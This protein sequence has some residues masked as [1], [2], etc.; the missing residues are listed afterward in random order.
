[1]IIRTVLRRLERLETRLLPPDRG[2]T[3]HTIVFVDADGTKAESMKFSH[4]APSRSWSSAQTKLASDNEYYQAVNLSLLRDAPYCRQPFRPRIRQTPVAPTRGLCCYDQVFYRSGLA[5]LLSF[6][7]WAQWAAYPTPG[8][9]K[10]P[11]GSPDYAAP[12]P[13]TPDGK[14]DFS[15]VWAPS[16]RSVVNSQEGQGVPGRPTGPF[17]DLNAVLPGGLPYQPWAKQL[18]DKRWTDFGKDNPDVGC[19][20]LG[21]LQDLTHQFPRRI[22]QSSSYV[23]LLMERNFSFRQIFLDGRPLPEDPN[24]TWNGYST[25]HWDGDVMVVESNGLRDG[26]WADYLGSPLTDQAKIT[27]R[28]RRPDFGTME[29]NVTVN[30]PKAY[31]KPW[32]VKLTWQLVTGTELME[33]ICIE[34]EKDVAHMVGK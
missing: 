2:V 10:L 4:G 27:E 20:P 14:P 21:I 23:A 29:I 15:G 12:A 30:D 34:N 22:L 31:T 1:M 17:W 3:E 24:P 13:K 6:P 26:L 5:L 11:D 33:Y 32:T 25:G 28:F 7:V 9:P 8:V 19:Y 16:R 18:R